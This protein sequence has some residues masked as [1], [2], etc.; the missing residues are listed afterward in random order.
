VSG[1]PAARAYIRPPARMLV[2]GPYVL[3]AEGSEAA[4]ALADARMA[5]QRQSADNAEPAGRSARG[6]IRNTARPPKSHAKGDA[7]SDAGGDAPA[8]PIG[9]SVTS[10]KQ[11]IRHGSQTLDFKGR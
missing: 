9:A 4:K 7:E 10:S 5:V 6:V 2:E 11:S 3:V 8:P 1:S